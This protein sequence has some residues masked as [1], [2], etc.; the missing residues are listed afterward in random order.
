ML[1]GRNELVQVVSE[2][3][4]AAGASVA[5]ENSEKGNF[6]IR[7][8]SGFRGSVI[9]LHVKDYRN[10]IFIIRSNYAIMRV[11]CISTNQAKRLEGTLRRIDFLPL[12]VHYYRPGRRNRAF[13]LLLLLE[14][15]HRYFIVFVPVRGGGA[16]EPV[17][18]LAYRTELLSG[19]STCFFLVLGV[20]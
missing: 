15:R 3:F 4:R 11:S 5:I 14:I 13:T 8:R 17:C 18:E 6:L 20:F 7:K 16:R 1:G 9:F 12:V 2:E 19:K 10:P